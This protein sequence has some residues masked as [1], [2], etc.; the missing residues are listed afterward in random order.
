[1]NFRQYFSKWS[2]WT[3][4]QRGYLYQYSV[5]VWVRFRRRLREFSERFSPGVNSLPESRAPHFG[6]SVMPYSSHHKTPNRRFGRVPVVPGP[7]NIACGEYR[8]GGLFDFFSRKG[9][10]KSPTGSLYL[11]KRLRIGHGSIQEKWQNKKVRLG[12]GSGVHFP[13]NIDLKRSPC[14][15]TFEAK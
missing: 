3:Q 11:G 15:R 9:E 4:N 13:G 8:F 12:W 1:M 14:Y 5:F 7:W 10:K 6:H 2:F